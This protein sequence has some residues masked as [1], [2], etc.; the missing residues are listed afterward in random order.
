MYRTY[1]DNLL[2]QQFKFSPY[3]YSNS[4]QILDH[5]VLFQKFFENHVF[6][7]PETAGPAVFWVQ[8]LKSGK[9]S[10]VFFSVSHSGMKYY[11]GN[12]Y[13]L[14]SEDVT[15]FELNNPYLYT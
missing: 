13:T 10:R 9:F 3:E 8:T 14:N 15:F 1:R 11:R 4:A 5:I 6:L 7:L 12:R 2:K